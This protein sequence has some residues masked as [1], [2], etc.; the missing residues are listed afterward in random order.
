MALLEVNHL[1]IVTLAFGEIIKNIINAVYIGI[2]GRGLHASLTSANKLVDAETGVILIN[3]PQGI[4]GTPR[5]SSFLIGI[6]LLL[7]SLVIA[8]NLT[9]PETEEPSCPSATTIS[10]LNPW[11]SISPSTS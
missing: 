5:D 9:I 6:L 8:L 1:A 4:T 3:G 2:D 7:V 11:A 10:P